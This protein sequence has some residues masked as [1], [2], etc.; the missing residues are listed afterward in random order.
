[1]LA[2]A[3]PE[4]VSCQLCK[5]GSERLTF[6]QKREVAVIVFL[7]FSSRTFVLPFA[8]RKKKVWVAAADAARSPDM[9]VSQNSRSA[10]R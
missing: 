4:N 8:K 6:R 1:M 2:G 7:L 3:R 10:L 9:G 5:A